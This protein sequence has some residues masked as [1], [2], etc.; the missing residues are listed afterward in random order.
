MLASVSYV[1]LLKSRVSEV[2]AFYFLDGP[3]KDRCFPIFLLRP[4][5]NAT[6]L[7]HALKRITEATAGRPFG[8]GL[9]R[10]SFGGTST[11]PAQQEFNLLFDTS[12]GYRSYFDL[13]E[14]IPEAVPVLQPS[15]E[16]T[17]LLLQLGNAVQLE[18]G[19]IVHQQR[20]APIPISDTILSLPPLPTDTIFVIDA[21]WARD[22]LQLEAWSIPIVRR[23]Y[24]AVPSAEIVVMASSFPDSFSHIVGDAEE[25]AFEDSH[26]DSVRQQVQ[27]ANLIYGDWGST[28]LPQSGGGGR[29]PPRIDL[30]KLL[31][32]HIFRAAPDD[33][34][35][36]FDIAVSAR[37]HPSFANV[38]DCW[39][40]T[41]VSQTD[42]NGLGIRGTKMNTSAR[43]NAHMTLRAGASGFSAQEEVP[44]QD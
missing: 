6:F 11:K 24:N 27:G 40:K 39:G 17:N 22:P 13:V 31:S 29:I 26:F 1:P 36:Y 33:D 25:I 30:A 44:Y 38:P 32:W 5:P 21:G 4:W 9:D 10:E 20:G 2:E 16:A 15:S 8:L 41:Q 7:E 28:R 18:R 12:R 37:T 19:L 14:S 43:I 42:G 34:Q 23:I 3:V 35:S